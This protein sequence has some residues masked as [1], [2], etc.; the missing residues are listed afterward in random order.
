MQIVKYYAAKDSRIEIINFQ[1]NKGI[2]IARNAGLKVATGK[3]V[4]CVDPDDYIE[5]NMLELAYNK[6]EETGFDSV[7]INMRL[8]SNSNQCF[9]KKNYCRK[10]SEGVVNITPENMNYFPVNAWNK[11]YRNDFIKKHNVVWSDGLIYEDL[12]FYYR[13]YTKSQK[14]YFI[15][16][17]LYVY[18][19]RNNSISNEKFI[20]K[21]RA[22]IFEAIER[23]YVYLNDAKIFAD[24]KNTLIGT[25]VQSIERSYNTNSVISAIVACL[26]KINFPDSYEKSDNYDFLKYFITY[27]R[28]S[29]LIRLFY[30]YHY[31]LI[32]W[33][34]KVIPNKKYRIRFRNKY[35]KYVFR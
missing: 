10:L 35:R 26:K 21:N 20:E 8:F 34:V 30:K 13:F 7:W 19:I 29:Q 31:L 3:Y 15:D 28:S 17:A 32:F 12:E 22:D 14:I 18:R 27:S 6:L 16:K 25:L 11:V 4:V 2:G 5:S 24:Y 23:I 33:L 9:I 1:T